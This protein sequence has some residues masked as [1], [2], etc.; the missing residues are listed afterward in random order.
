MTAAHSRADR[1]GQSTTAQPIASRRR[2]P[3]P[4]ICSTG[5]PRGIMTTQS[6]CSLGL[7]PRVACTQQSRFQLARPVVHDYGNNKVADK[8]FRTLK[9]RTVSRE[10]H[11]R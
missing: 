4:R 2:A 1:K 3:I 11:E 7:D 8:A 6:R 5:L 10:D 9:L